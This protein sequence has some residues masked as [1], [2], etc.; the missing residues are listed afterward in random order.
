MR[1][2]QRR[3]QLQR[4]SRQTLGLF[5]FDL[6]PVAYASR[7]LVV[8]RRRE[9]GVKGSISGVSINGALKVFFRSRHRLGSVLL[10]L[11]PP[12]HEPFTGIR[13]GNVRVGGTEP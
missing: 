6:S 11:I 9:R 3:I 8:L 7:R 10:Q 4:L 13:L 12:L 1:P 5:A 2:E